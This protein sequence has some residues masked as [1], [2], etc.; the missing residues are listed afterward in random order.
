MDG[1][2]F[3]LYFKSIYIEYIGAPW[4]F[5]LFFVQLA[6]KILSR[7]YR[8][9]VSNVTIV[10]RLK[11]SDCVDNNMIWHGSTYVYVYGFMRE[12]VINISHDRARSYTQHCSSYDL[13]LWIL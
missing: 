10:I 1:S 3:Q 9:R 8:G 11:T 5:I 12:R 13:L 7:K 6:E 4:K 2:A